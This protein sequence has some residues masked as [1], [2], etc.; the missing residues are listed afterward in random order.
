[1]LVLLKSALE[2]FGIVYLRFS[3]LPRLWCV[4]L[5]GINA[6]ALLF[7]THIEA[8]VVLIVT[9]VSVIIQSVIYSKTGFTRILGMA[10]ILWLPMFA[11]MATRTGEIAST[12][13]MTFWVLLLFLTN[14]ICLII[15]FIDAG[16]FQRGERQP[17]YVWNGT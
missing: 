4:W 3:W 12:P 2:I 9:A 13:G 10:H 16:R 5:V 17:H 14:A 7:I 1:M 11:W 6:A 8:Q 15:D